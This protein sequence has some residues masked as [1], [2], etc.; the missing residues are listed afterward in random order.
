MKNGLNI[1]I[2]ISFRFL[3]TQMDV[4]NLSIENV[5]VS[6]EITLIWGAVLQ[7]KL[8]TGKPLKQP[9]CQFLVFIPVIF[10]KIFWSSKTLFRSFLICSTFREDITINIFTLKVPLSGCNRIK[11]DR[12]LFYIVLQ[13]SGYWQ[14]ICRFFITIFTCRHFSTWFRPIFADALVPFCIVTCQKHCN[15]RLQTASEQFLNSLT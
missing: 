7:N 12:Y 8:W 11:D 2:V 9:F 15:T 3:L 4:K 14:R 6:F 13:I 10:Q 1:D 5:L